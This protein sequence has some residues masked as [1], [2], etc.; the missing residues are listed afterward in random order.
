MKTF[1]RESNAAVIKEAVLR[2]LLRGGQVYYLHNEVE[3]IEKTGGA[4]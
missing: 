4:R 1:V 2:E 3:S